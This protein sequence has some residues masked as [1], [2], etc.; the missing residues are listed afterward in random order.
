MFEKR[1]SFHLTG[2]ISGFA[3][4]RGT[5]LLSLIRFCRSLT[6]SAQIS[7]YPLPIQSLSSL[8]SITCIDLG[9]THSAYDVCIRNIRGE[10]VLSLYWLDNL[11]VP[12]IQILVT[13]STN[14]SLTEAT[15]PCQ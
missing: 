2:D 13:L 10:L 15:N 4:C 12:D 6:Q 1:A 7:L 3:T 5:G 9:A 14:A 11:S 8:P